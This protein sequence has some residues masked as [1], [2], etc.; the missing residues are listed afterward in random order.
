MAIL[1]FIPLLEMSIFLFLCMIGACRFKTVE[2]F[3]NWYTQVAGK[4]IRGDIYLVRPEGKL[5]TCETVQDISDH[6]GV[7]L[8]VEWGGHCRE[9]QEKR[10]IPVYRK[11]KALRLHNFLRDKL[12]TWT[13]NGS[14]VQDIWKNFKD[15]IFMA[16][17]V[18]FRTKMWNQNWTT[19]TTRRRLDD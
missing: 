2:F 18:L 17:N 9:T 4:P 11:T 8:D 12:P 15:I 6:C 5:I 13:N 19:I 1:L 10:F 7:L 16:S 14:C 3:F